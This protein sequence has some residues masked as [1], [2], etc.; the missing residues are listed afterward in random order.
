MA[1]SSSVWLWLPTVP[2]TANLW[3][4]SGSSWRVKPLVVLYGVG[5]EEGEWRLPLILKVVVLVRLA[6]GRDKDSLRVSRGRSHALVLFGKGL[7]LRC[8]R[9]VTQSLVTRQEPTTTGFGPSG[10]TVV[11]PGPPLSHQGSLFPS[12]RCHNAMWHAPGPYSHEHSYQQAFRFV[13]V[14]VYGGS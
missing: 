9:A 5:G 1:T 7:V 8:L 2:I 6:S 13:T 4:S 12:I 3:S 11:P 10:T 14:G